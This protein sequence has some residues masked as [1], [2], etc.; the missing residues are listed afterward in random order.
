MENT[1][2]YKQIE[3]MPIP[4]GGKREGAGRK[5]LAPEMKKPKTI[6]IRVDERLLGIIETLKNE[7]LNEKELENLIEIVKSKKEAVEKHT[8]AI[9]I[10]EEDEKELKEK[11]EVINDKRE[12]LDKKIKE[13]EKMNLTKD[14]VMLA[15]TAA[16]WCIGNEAKYLIKTIKK[17]TKIE[18]KD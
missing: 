3:L 10:T 9:K 11:I 6:A 14:H 2:K 8:D 1:K 17:I 15:T 18:I 13:I 4:K 16:A 7:N 5:P 12:L